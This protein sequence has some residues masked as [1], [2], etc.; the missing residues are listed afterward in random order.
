MLNELLRRQFDLVSLEKNTLYDMGGQSLCRC[1]VSQ[2][3]Y[4]LLE[5]CQFDRTTRSLIPQKRTTNLEFNH[6]CHSAE[7]W[8]WWWR[9]HDRQ[10]ICLENLEASSTFVLTVVGRILLSE[11]K[12]EEYGFKGAHIATK[13]QLSYNECILLHKKPAYV[14]VHLEFI[15]RRLSRLRT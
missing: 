13:C 2:Y 11:R 1:M 15:R 7:R 5:V 9:R 4:D 8:W 12:I 10:S 14:K 3:S 6:P